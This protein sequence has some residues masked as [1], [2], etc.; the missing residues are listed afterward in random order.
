MQI[1]WKALL[2]YM[3]NA[4]AAL[5]STLR[6]VPRREIEVVE[7]E[8]SVSL[9]SNYVNFLLSMGEDSGELRPFGPTQVHTFSK[10]REMLPP[11]DYSGDRFFKVAFESD[12]LALAYLDTFLDLGSSDG[13]DARVVQFE[14][15]EDV[16]PAV[17][18]VDWTFGESLIECVFS[19]LELRRRSYGAKV[20]GASADLAYALQLKE[21]AADILGRHGFR[22]ALTGLKRV[23]AF[24]LD[25][26]SALL[27]VSD[28][29][30]LLNIKLASDDLVS[31]EKLI[32]LLL[33]ELPS[34]ELA[35]LP[36]KRVDRPSI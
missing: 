31:L 2:E 22:H 32:A 33:A 14:T 24:S 28:P 34:S 10:L 30:N 15:G 23:G 4:D 29:T 25:H 35:E 5:V 12:D 8:C 13:M 26:A 21:T 9:P 19:D 18:G 3:L 7:D 20:V 17:E 11:E 36:L 27:T 1:D 6:G 16:I